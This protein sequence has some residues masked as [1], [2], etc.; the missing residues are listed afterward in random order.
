MDFP[1]FFLI[2]TIAVFTQTTAGFGIALIAMPLIVQQ[3]GVMIAAPLVAALALATRLMMIRQY[4]LHLDLSD[5]WQITLASVLGIPF[6]FYIFY[7]LDQHIVE[8][9]LG[10]IILLYVGWLIFQPAVRQFE[11][12][13]WAYALGF[14]SGVLGAAYN[15]GGPPTVIYGTGKRWEPIRFKCN[16]QIIALL[17]SFLVIAIRMRHGEYTTQVMHY[18]LM[19]IPA[20]GLGL[21]LGFWLDRYIRMEIFRRVILGMLLITALQMMF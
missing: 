18:F 3:A 9:M 17:N 6:G 11:S 5:I 20:M 13:L 4:R 12:P 15:V 8:V 14:A 1:L 2:V 19:A 7:T 10:V 21:L 16:L